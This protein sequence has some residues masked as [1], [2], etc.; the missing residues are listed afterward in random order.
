M[1]TVVTIKSVRVFVNEDS[2]SVALTI[3]TPIP[4][5]KLNR[6]KNVI[7]EA[8]VDTISFS[9]GSLTRQLCDLSDDI[10]LYRSSRGQ[11]FG[12]KEFG[13]ILFGAKLTI[14]RELKAAGEVIGEGD[15][16]YVVERDC[17]ITT[18]TNVKLSDRAIRQ[19]DAACAL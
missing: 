1:S 4:G 2:A 13:V 17:Y 19:L 14:T 15:S 10:A 11:S 3:D 7:E 18:I 9:R 12:Q 5:F 16:A 8:N 6:D